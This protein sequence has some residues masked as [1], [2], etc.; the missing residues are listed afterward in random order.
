MAPVGKALWAVLLGVGLLSAGEL[1]AK[2]LYQCVTESGRQTL[3]S[4]PCHQDSKAPQGHQMDRGAPTGSLRVTGDRRSR[5]DSFRFGGHGMD[6]F[7]DQGHA[8]VPYSRRRATPPPKGGKARDGIRIAPPDEPKAQPAPWAP[9]LPPKGMTARRH[10][11]PMRPFASEPPAASSAPRRSAEPFPPMASLPPSAP[12]APGLLAPRLSMPSVEEGE[13]EQIQGLE[14]PKRP[15][16]KSTPALDEAVKRIKAAKKP[17][18]KSAEKSTE[19]ATEART[20]KPMDEEGSPALKAD[21]LSA[22]AF[23]DLIWPHV[24]KS[25][26]ERIWELFFRHQNSGAHLMANLKRDGQGEGEEAER[27]RI[28]HQKLSQILVEMEQQEMALRATS[29]I[30][31]P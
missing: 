29:A 12:P 22:K 5:S 25:N 18:E 27:A 19:N 6:P 8:G 21:E 1:H 3:R 4:T 10:A 26:R 20:E 9:N 16:L 31:A 11:P 13:M 7:R 28:L 17:V 14:K 23:H 24:Q 2:R 30:R 15:V